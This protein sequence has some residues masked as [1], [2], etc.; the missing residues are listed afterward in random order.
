MADFRIEKDSMGAIKVPQ[1][2]WYGSQTQ[3]AI[4]NFDYSPNPMPTSFIRSLIEIKRAATLANKSL[5]E[6]DSSKAVAIKDACDF[7][8]N[9]NLSNEKLMANFPVS[10]YQTGS[11]TSSNMNANEVIAH[12][13]EQQLSKQQGDAVNIHPNDDVNYGQSSNDVIPSC[14]QLSL[15]SYCVDYFLPAIDQAI[16]KLNNL[17]E[18]YRDIIK[19][20]RTHLMDA[21]PISLGEEVATWAFQ[22]SES[23]ERVIGSLGRLT[24]IPLGGTAVGTGINRHPQ[25]P[26]KVCELLSERLSLPI[27]PCKNFSSR[28]SAQSPTL[29]MHGQLK[30]LATDV[31]KIANDLRWMNS[32]PNQGLGELQ[33]KALQPGSSIMPSKVNPV[34]PES[35]AMMCAQ[36]LGNDVTLSVANQSGNFQL[37]VMLPLIAAKSLESAELITSSLIAL[38]EKGLSDISVNEA[39]LK[40]SVSKNPILITAL[41]KKIGY[42]KAAKIAKQALAEGRNII[43][44]AVEQ[45][46]LSEQ[47]L[48]ELLDPKKLA[49]PFDD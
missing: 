25:F 46:D 29:E 39:K 26:E 31:I 36:V 48:S 44:I 5:S 7:L 34:I 21:M 47:E 14:V 2:A 23:R 1:D 40:S 37:N 9:R 19:T 20:G 32:G 10:I 3:R 12:L 24:Q 41:N 33:L 11:G 38:A 49:F 13:A 45:T 28:M 18:Q 17:A 30:V 16:A 43:D 27:K 8:L 22:L 4:E 6:I 35:I 15:A 42:E